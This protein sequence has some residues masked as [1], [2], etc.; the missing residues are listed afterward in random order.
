MTSK[1]DINRH[2]KYTRFACRGKHEEWQKLR[3]E[4]SRMIRLNRKHIGI[5][6]KQDGR[7]WFSMYD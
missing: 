6:T 5:Q 7:Y 3:A 2:S 4:I 1:Y